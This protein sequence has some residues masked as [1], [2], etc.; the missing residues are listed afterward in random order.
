MHA[1]ESKVTPQEEEDI[2]VVEWKKLT[3]EVLFDLY[4]IYSNI[5]DVL[6]AYLSMVQ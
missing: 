4:P 5:K 3:Q 6:R 1:A 2:E